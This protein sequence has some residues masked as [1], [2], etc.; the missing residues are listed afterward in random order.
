MS[1]F[2]L[3]LSPAVSDADIEEEEV[4]GSG[5]AVAATSCKGVE[6]VRLDV[7]HGILLSPVSGIRA[8]SMEA[9]GAWATSEVGTKGE[10]VLDA[11]QVMI[12]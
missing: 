5:S 6:G 4:F 9:G 11:G 12:P 3:S 1:P 7:R 10:A 8:G 2:P